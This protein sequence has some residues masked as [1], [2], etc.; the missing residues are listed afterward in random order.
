M[1]AIC[2]QSLT[3]LSEA[4]AVGLGETA[5]SFPHSIILE[6]HLFH[7]SDHCTNSECVCV[8]AL[9]MRALALL[10]L[11]FTLTHGNKVTL[12]RFFGEV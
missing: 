5:L 10:G 12:V 8:C 1:R 6:F 7:L 4:S 11:S 2:R 9:F 3:C